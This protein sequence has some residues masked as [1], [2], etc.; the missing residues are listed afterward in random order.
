MAY[1]S[2]VHFLS[3]GIHTR[4]FK[5]VDLLLFHS[6]EHHRA[7]M[8]EAPYVTEDG[9]ICCGRCNKAMPTW[10]AVQT[11]YSRNE[12][13]AIAAQPAV[14]R[15]RV[16]QERQLAR[17]QRMAAERA[18]PA[19]GEAEAVEVRADMEDDDNQRQDE[20]APTVSPTMSFEPVHVQPMRY[21]AQPS[22]NDRAW[23]AAPCVTDW[24]SAPST[25][26]HYQSASSS[27][28]HDKVIFTLLNRE[29]QLNTDG[30]ILYRLVEIPWSELTPN[31]TD[32]APAPS[33]AVADPAQLTHAAV[34]APV[35]EPP[36]TPAEMMNKAPTATLKE[37]YEKCAAPPFQKDGVLRSEY[38]MKL[39][40]TSLTLKIFKWYLKS[41]L[42]HSDAQVCFWYR[43]P[44]QKFGHAH[45]H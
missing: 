25:W 22:N 29:R 24:Q 2:L 11:H 42:T 44:A 36:V 17:R 13:I 3:C 6:S 45:A 20:A 15:Q 12:G 43:S 4:W 41:S 39:N 33:G 30:V 10:R 7:H 5:T 16:S 34:A 26:Q 31:A 8:F 28:G 21:E 40:D 37:A 18:E 27:I 38:P 9:S 1:N 35:T 14:I 19:D 32:H 23:W